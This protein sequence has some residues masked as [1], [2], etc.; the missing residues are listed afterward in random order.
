MKINVTPDPF[1]YWYTP[2]RSYRLVTDVST[3]F[4]FWQSYTKK[5]LGF[6]PF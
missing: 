2:A 5:R 3:G 6:I 1:T 4:I